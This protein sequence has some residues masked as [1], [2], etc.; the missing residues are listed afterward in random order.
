MLQRFHF[1]EK[2]ASAKNKK[3]IIIIKIK[4]KTSGQKKP[5][6]LDSKPRPF[7]RMRH[8]M[9]WR[10]QNVYVREQLAH[11]FDIIIHKV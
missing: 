3:I 8:L 5:T 11:I 10:L 6:V 4:I 9:A 2:I 7:A 1:G